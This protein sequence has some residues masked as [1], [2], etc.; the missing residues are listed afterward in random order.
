MVG[1]D[2]TSPDGVIRIWWFPSS[3][4]GLFVVAVEPHDAWGPADV[5]GLS[6]SDLQAVLG[7]VAFPFVLLLDFLPN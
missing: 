4:E 6:V 3:P 5:L 7:V 1:M 2:T